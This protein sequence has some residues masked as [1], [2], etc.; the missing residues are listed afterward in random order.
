[1][2]WKVFTGKCDLSVSM[3]RLSVDIGG[4]F[5]PFLLTLISKKGKGPKSCV[6]HLDVEGNPVQY[7]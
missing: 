7:T 6:D 5:I 2:N 4:Y 1:M 3:G